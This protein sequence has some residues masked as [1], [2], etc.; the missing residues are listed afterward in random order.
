MLDEVIVVGYGVQKRSDVTGAISSVKAEKANQ[1]PTTSVAE[2]LRGAAPGL[3]VNLGSAEPGGTSSILIR[4]RRSLSGDNAPLYV[5]DGLPVDSPDMINP[6]D[7]ASI[8]ILKDA[9]SA[10][11]YGSRSANGVI[12]ITTKSGTPGKSQISAKYQMSGNTV[13]NFTWITGDCFSVDISFVKHMRLRTGKLVDDPALSW[14]AAAVQFLRACCYGEKNGIA[15]LTIEEQQQLFR[16][17]SEEN[18]RVFREKQLRLFGQ[19]L[20]QFGI[21]ADPD[22]VALFTNLRLTVMVIRRAIPDT[23]P[24]FV[25]EAAD[26][27]VDLQIHAI[28]DA[29]ER[30]REHS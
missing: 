27:T 25:P 12:L 9:A 2:M 5:V 6:G 29:L 30:M 7:I 26:K 3:Q 22:R 10:A 15:V 8:E 19:I 17:L 18:C 13:A 1:I 11:I 21:R 14:R 16:R 4:G 24:L 23:L 20:E 28:V